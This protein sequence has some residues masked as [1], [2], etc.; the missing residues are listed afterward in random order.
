LSRSTNPN[1]HVLASRALVRAQLRRWDAALVD[2]EMAIN[3]QP[4]VIGYVAKSIALVGKGEKYKC[5]AACDI[6]SEYFHSSHVS[7][8]LLIKAIILF[9]AGEHR[10]AISRMDDLIAAVPLD[11]MCY[12]VQAYMYTRLGN[13]QMQCND[14]EGAIQSFERARAQMQYHT[15]RP[16]F[17]VSLVRYLISITATCLLAVSDRSLDGNL[18]ISTS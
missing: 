13:S 9:M 7:F 12:V 10:N 14:Y 4:S 18:M 6:A 11:S 16:L 17:V 3:I 8:L 5:Y 15:T 1:H 2:A